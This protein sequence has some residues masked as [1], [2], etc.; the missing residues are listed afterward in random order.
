[1]ICRGS[2]ARKHLKSVIVW[3]CCSRKGTVNDTMKTGRN[4]LELRARNKQYILPNFKMEL[5]TI[6]TNNLDS[7]QKA[8]IVKDTTV[9]Q[10][11]LC[12]AVGRY[13]S[14]ASVS[15]PFI[16]WLGLTQRNSR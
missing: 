5:G 12:A 7:D 13:S 8:G 14:C 3:V 11:G 2:V 10:L 1:M 9:L 4:V 6:G 16:I 15:H